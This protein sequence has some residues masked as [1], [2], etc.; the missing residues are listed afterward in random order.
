ME[1]DARRVT[2]I[3]EILEKWS[4]VRMVIK[5][6]YVIKT[7]TDEELHEQ[8]PAL[9]NMMHEA[10]NGKGFVERILDDFSSPVKLEETMERIRKKEEEMER[11][12][13]EV[14]FSKLLEERA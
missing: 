2:Y 5:A 8:Y 11:I 13:A 12:D 6:A 14:P 1:Q 10:M 9:E 7:L 4:E 3:E